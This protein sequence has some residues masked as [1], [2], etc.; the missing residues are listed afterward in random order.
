[1]QTTYFV[2]SNDKVF[3]SNVHADI[4]YELCEAL[5]LFTFEVSTN[6]KN[7]S[8]CTLD[9]AEWIGYSHGEI[10]N[11]LI[12]LISNKGLANT[13]VEEDVIDYLS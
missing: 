9:C 5:D 4:N 1:M 12:E 8:T 10:T 7:E 13:D 3:V 11:A 2:V 6:D